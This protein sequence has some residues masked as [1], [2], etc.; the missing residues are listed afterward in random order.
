MSQRRYC[1]YR[2]DAQTCTLPAAWSILVGVD[3]ELFACDEHRNPTLMSYEAKD[4]AGIFPIGE[5]DL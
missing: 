3:L 2:D 5:D 1:G 4:V